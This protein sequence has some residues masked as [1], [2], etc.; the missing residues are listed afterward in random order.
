[1]SGSSLLVWY[2][3]TPSSLYL[4]VV[5]QNNESATGLTLS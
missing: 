1:M 5:G 4:A 3:S 2:A